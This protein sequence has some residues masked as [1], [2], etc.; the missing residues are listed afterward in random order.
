MAQPT[1]VL[2]SQVPAALTVYGLVHVVQAHVV[3]LWALQLASV[4]H[5]QVPA[6]VPAVNRGLEQVEQV[7]VALYVAQPVM[8]GHWQP[9]EPLETNGAVQVVHAH[10]VGLWTPQLVMAGH[11]QALPVRVYGLGHEQPPEPLETNGAAQVEQAQVAL[12]DA[13]PVM[14]AHCTPGRVG[15][16]WAT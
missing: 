15:G 13:Q 11:W 4:A 16:V 6:V 1:T 2:H 3:E 14:V 10:V 9:P 12:Y 8:A 5:S 7:Q